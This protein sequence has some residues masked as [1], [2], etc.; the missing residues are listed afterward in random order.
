M[1]LLRRT[2]GT[3]KSEEETIIIDDLPLQE[4]GTEAV[5]TTIPSTEGKAES[6]ESIKEARL[7]EDTRLRDGLA[8]NPLQEKENLITRMQAA[9]HV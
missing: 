2:D 6:I 1:H 7:E 9:Y 5:T 3:R 8:I 4:V